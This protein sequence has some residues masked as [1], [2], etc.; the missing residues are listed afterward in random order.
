MTNGNTEYFS[1]EHQSV[2][3]A[4]R[5]GFLEE[6]EL[7]LSNAILKGLPVAQQFPDNAYF[8][9]D[10][11]HPKDVMLIDSMSNLNAHLLVGPAVRAFL[12]SESI[13]GL[14]FLPVSIRDHKGRVA[15]SDY[16]IVHPTR[17]VD[18]IDQAS[19]EFEWNGLDPTV[20]SMV[21]QM[22]LKRAALGPEDKLFR[23]KHY[24]TQLLIRGDVAER[25][26]GKRFTG[27]A[28]LPA[29]Q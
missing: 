17:V 16:R 8:E 27:V 10:P 24:E 5:L 23:P 26:M 7:D 14:E 3:G 13:E 20:M 6:L 1:I 15:S 19:S 25:L 9:M 4:A 22:V 21:F 18:C 2:E 12:Q 28:L 11:E 29:E